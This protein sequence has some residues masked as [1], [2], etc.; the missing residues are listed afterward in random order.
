LSDVKCRGADDLEGNMTDLERFESS[1]NCAQTPPSRSS[2]EPAGSGPW[3][4]GRAHLIGP[5]DPHSEV[6]AERLRQLLREIFQ[7]AGGTHDDWDTH[8]RTMRDERRTAVLV[9]PTRVYSNP[10]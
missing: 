9:D 10:G 8:D 1:P 7:A 5:D 3:S 4:E 6:D 2:S